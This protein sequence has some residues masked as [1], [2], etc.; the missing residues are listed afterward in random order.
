M[1]KIKGTY[2]SAVIY[3]D[4]AEDYALAQV[5]M[6]CDNEAAAGSKICLMPDVHPGKVGPIGLTMMIGRRILPS[7]LGA[8]IGCGVSYFKTKPAK[9]EFQKLDKIIRENIPSGRHN[10][11]EP[12]R[13]SSDFDFSDLSCGTHIDQKRAALSLGTL[14]GGNHFLEV[15]RDE[16][17]NLY[18]VVHSGSRYLGSAVTEYYLKAGQKEFK[19]KG[20]S[21]PYELTYLTDSLMEDYLHDVQAVQGFA[22]LNREIMLSELQKKLK[23]KPTYFGE[24]VHN[25]ADENRILRKGAIAAYAGDEVIIPLNMRDGILLGYGKGNADWNFSAP[26][27]AGRVLSREAA[28]NSHTLSEFRESMQGIYSPSISGATLDE[29][30]FAYRDMDE[31]LANIK[32]TV[33]ITKRLKPVYNYKAGG[34]E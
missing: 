21:L 16:K 18:F 33:T 15:D 26:H 25:Y 20:I 3:S 1:Q 7:L 31:I 23:L 8:D 4:T 27:G 6:I 22:M 19:A 17:E 11:K 29:A 14:G 24:S 10:R 2:A 13:Y 9:I 28:R 12:H 32:E 34:K 30:P 5:K